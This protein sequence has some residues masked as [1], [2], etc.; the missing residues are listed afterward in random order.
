MGLWEAYMLLFSYFLHFTEYGAV[1]CGN[2]VFGSEL[3]GKE[4]GD[5]KNV[6]EFN[7]VFKKLNLEI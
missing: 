4:Y 5:N 6:Q 2:S 1:L 3:G 7:R